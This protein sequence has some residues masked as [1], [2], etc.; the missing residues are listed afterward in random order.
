MKLIFSSILILAYCL[1]AQ[2]AESAD[3]ANSNFTLKVTDNDGNT[4]SFIVAAQVLKKSA[5]F[6]AMVGSQDYKESI[7][8]MIALKCHSLKGFEK[9]LN[10]LYQEEIVF[11]HNLDLLAIMSM[12][13]M[14]II[15]NLD[16]ELLQILDDA[17]YLAGF[18]IG[19]FAELLKFID[20]EDFRYKSDY[21]NSVLI[22]I[23]TY[24]YIYDN[25]SLDLLN[26]LNDSP[27]L[28]E[29]IEEIFRQSNADNILMRRDIQL[30]KKLDQE[31]LK[32]DNKI[33]QK[34]RKVRKRLGNISNKKL[35]GYYIYI[36]FDKKIAQEVWSIIDSEY[37]G[38]F[39]IT[40]RTSHIRD[41]HYYYGLKVK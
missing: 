23:D 37:P 13:E 34:V 8:K 31:R 3:S 25:C 28:R 26:Y 2:A 15:K 19:Q 24:K 36:S 10:F 17:D 9:V 35:I 16:Q 12:Q 39:I 40:C 11:D 33:Q 20:E 30:A 21:I 18:S 41:W 22:Y 14:L 7:E 6:H 29:K 38:L 5:Y 32:R 27:N 4:A 1:G